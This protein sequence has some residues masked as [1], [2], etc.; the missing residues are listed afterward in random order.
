M[1]AW[2]RRAIVLSAIIAGAI[3]VAAYAAPAVFVSPKQG[4]AWWTTQPIVRPMMKSIDGIPLAALNS[5]RKNV[6]VMAQDLCYAEDVKRTTYVGLTRET[7]AEIDETLSSLKGDPFRQIVTTPDGR[8][9][10]ARAAIGEE[11]DTK[12]PVGMVIIYDAQTR[13]I[14]DLQTYENDPFNFLWPADGPALLGLSGCFEC[15]DSNS[16]YYDVTRRKFYWEYDGH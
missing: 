12:T 6:E 4:H 16:L 1:M 9:Y 15:G 3:S 8:R 14:T 10:I 2:R 13:V 7:Q 11:C 5:F